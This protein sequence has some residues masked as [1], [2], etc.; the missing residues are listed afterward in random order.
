MDNRWEQGREVE[1]NTGTK[2][3]LRHFGWPA[4]LT[5]SQCL[6][7]AGGLGFTDA[8]GMGWILWRPLIFP[9]VC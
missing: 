3:G 1:A 6:G 9:W 2:E 7:S 8:K 5:Y 4:L